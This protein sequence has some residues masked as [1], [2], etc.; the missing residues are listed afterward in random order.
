[1]G[2][3]AGD[4]IVI[5]HLEKSFVVDGRA[6]HALAVE[7]LRIQQGEF[8]CIVGPS[9]CGKTTL[10]RILGGLETPNSGSVDFQIRHDGRP[11]QSLVFQE[12]GVFPW[13]TVLGNVTF[14]LTVRGIPRTERE[15]IA[16]EYLRKLG[17]AAFETAYP[18]Q[19][20]GGMRQRVNLARAFANDPA[21]LLMDEPLGALDEQTKMLVQEDLLNLWEG[22][23]KTVIFIT[24]SLDEAIVLGDRV[25]VMS[26]RPGR[27]KAMYEIG[28]P[29]PRNALELRNHPDFVAIRSR[30]WDAL[31]EEVLS[32]GAAASKGPEL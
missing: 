23:R 8:L 9:G 26:Q 18:R 6:L 10:L 4:G 12:Q 14:G 3:R 17:L 32:S 22:T 24:H 28:L 20:S 27:I 19:L 1:M 11:P 7:D 25:A 29:R 21:V 30:V 16:R 5:R 2:T 13:L 31:R 15:P